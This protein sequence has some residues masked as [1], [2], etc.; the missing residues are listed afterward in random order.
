M[1]FKLEVIILTLV[2]LNIKLCLQIKEDMIIF[3]NVSNLGLIILNTPNFKILPPLMH[4]MD[5]P[6]K[7]GSL[8][9]MFNLTNLL[10]K[11]L[12]TSLL[13]KIINL[14]TKNYTTLQL[15]LRLKKGNPFRYQHLFRVKIF[16]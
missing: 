5:L 11:N 1:K 6:Q 16:K 7:G 9:H 14:L 13:I 8:I 4:H 2:Q 15:K 10:Q 12:S 3:L